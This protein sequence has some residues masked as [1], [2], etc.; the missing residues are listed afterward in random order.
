[1]KNKRIL[2]VINT[3]DRGG[4]ERSLINLLC[5]KDFSDAD[6]DLVILTG[7]A[8]LMDELPP[9]VNVINTHI[10]RKSVV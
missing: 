10:D 4:A 1:M 3:L 6:V 7:K 8:A 2:F 5:E 9:N